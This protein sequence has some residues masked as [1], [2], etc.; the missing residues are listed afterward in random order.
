MRSSPSA[1]A[2][3]AR[4]A[5]LTSQAY[6]HRGLHGGSTCENS[7]SAFAAAIAGGHGIELDVRLSRDGLATVFHD[8]DVAR[9][10]G[11]AGEVSKMTAAELGRLSLAGRF[12][13]IE[14]L[15]AILDFVAGRAPMLIELKTDGDPRIAAH[16]CLSVRHALE[17]RSGRHAVMSFDP[18]VGAWYARHAPDVARGLVMSAQARRGWRAFV[19]NLLALRRARPHFIAYD[20]RSLP[21]RLAAR[22]RARGLPVLGWTVRTDEERAVAATHADQIIF[23]RT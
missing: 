17:G 19:R 12:D 2:E 13:R 3:H 1:R 11:A 6:A 18:A 15:P 8:A 5:W 7:R 10:T 23:E 14:T 4:H 9:L 21:S 20:V 22:F 16:L